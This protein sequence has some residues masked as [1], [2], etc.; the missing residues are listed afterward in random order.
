MAPNFPAGLSKGEF[1]N[2]NSIV[3]KSTG[4][5]LLMAA[6]L[7][8]AL[9]AMG[10]F[11]ATGVG[12]AVNA[13]PEP[14]IS[15]S[16]N[17]PGATGVTMTV[18]FQVSTGVVENGDQDIVVT[19]PTAYTTGGNPAV[20]AD[21]VTVTV[22]QLDK[23][24]GLVTLD[25]STV[26]IAYRADVADTADVNESDDNVV[27]G[28]TV[29]VVIAGLTNPDAVSVPGEPDDTASP[30]PSDDD[31]QILQGTTDDANPIRYADPGISFSGGTLSLSSTTAG[32]AVQVVV[33]A[34]AEA[35]KTSANDITVNLANFGVPSTISLRGPSLSK[36]VPPPMHTTAY[37]GEP[38]SIVVSGTKVTLSLF[39]RFPGA[40]GAAGTLTD[41][42]RI[43]F[44]QSAGITNPGTAGTATVSVGDGD[45]NG[46][47]LTATIQS[48]VTL[49]KGSGARGTDVTVTGVGLGGGGA[50]VFLVDGELCRP[51]RGLHRR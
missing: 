13:S 31:I 51:G 25:T 32:A 46:H 9:F 26:D 40:P 33:N 38:G 35:A 34:W 22:T 48:A 27:A 11:S 29:T 12:A 6:A 43:T 5:A 3:G 8:A 23:E 16:N 4:I 19:L 41:A 10:V 30:N 36:T 42:Y 50:T 21:G 17:L 24:V 28:E 39:A 7:I 1:Q 18:T 45:T 49:S 47:S 20:N 15:L 2:M 37:V 14:S 44:K